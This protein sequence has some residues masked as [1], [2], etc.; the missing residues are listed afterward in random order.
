METKDNTTIATYTSPRQAELAIIK[1]HEN[2][3]D[4]KKIALLEKEFQMTSCETFCGKDNESSKEK[5]LQ[6][7]LKPMPGKITLLS[8]NLP[9]DVQTIAKILGIEIKK[10]NLQTI[11]DKIVLSG[12]ERSPLQ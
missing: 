9:S 12:G 5:I 2:G 6:R 8:E 4:I 1:L 10:I 11:P 3:F 7:I